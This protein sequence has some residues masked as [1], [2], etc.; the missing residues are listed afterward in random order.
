MLPKVP[1]PRIALSPK[2]RHSVF[3]QQNFEKE[4][5][6]ENVH[7]KPQFEGLKRTTIQKEHPSP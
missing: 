1:Y 3:T 4:E 6:I 7:K 2:L 5:T